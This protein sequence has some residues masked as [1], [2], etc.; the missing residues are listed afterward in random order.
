MAVLITGYALG[1]SLVLAIGAQSAFV[2]RQGLLPAHVFWVALT[3]GLQDALPIIAG[4]AGVGALTS[5]LPRL[6]PVMAWGG[7]TLFFA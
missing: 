2:R 3:C 1:F 5:A 6:T 4:I 7:A